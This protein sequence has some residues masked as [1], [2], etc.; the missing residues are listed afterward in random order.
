MPRI[1]QKAL[2]SNFFGELLRTH[3]PRTR[4]NRD[5]REGWAMGKPTSNSGTEKELLRS[6]ETHPTDT[7]ASNDE[8]AMNFPGSQI[9]KN[10][11]RDAYELIV[12]LH[13]HACVLAIKA[14]PS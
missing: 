2:F 7:I 1:L 6:L 5:N 13:A 14:N 9:K 10:V 8:S 4:G 12:G 3:L 11:E